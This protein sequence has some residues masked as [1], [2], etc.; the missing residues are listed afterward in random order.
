VYAPQGLSHC[1]LVQVNATIGNSSFSYV[2]LDDQIYSVVLE[3]GYYDLFSFN[4][5][6]QRVMLANG[7]YFIIVATGTPV[8]L[9]NITNNI[10]NNVVE[11]QAIPYDSY[12]EPE[13]TPATGSAPFPLNYPYF[14][15]PASSIREALGF[16]EGEYPN[17]AASGPIVPQ[18]FLGSYRGSLYPPYVPLY[19]K[20]SNPKFANQGGVSSSAHIFRKRFDAITNSGYKNRLEYGSAVAN[21]LAYSVPVPGYTL[22]DKVGYPQPQ[23]PKFPQYQPDVMLRCES[24][25]ISG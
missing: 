1:K 19:Y 5:A 7:H 16:E 24:T 6:L 22:K 4:Q 3:D 12:P 10:E 25:Q 11:L 9:L 20:P 15:I 8:F 2:W 17:P 23:V 21:A 14:V 18:S 13:Y